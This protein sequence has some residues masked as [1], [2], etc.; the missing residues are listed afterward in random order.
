MAKY[1]QLVHSNLALGIIPQIPVE[2]VRLELVK[3]ESCSPT[4][5]VKTYRITCSLSLRHSLRLVMS[6]LFGILF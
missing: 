5:N 2:G 6:V 4:G 3:A 1:E